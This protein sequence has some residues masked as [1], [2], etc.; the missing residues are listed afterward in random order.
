ML[1]PPKPALLP[2]IINISPLQLSCLFSKTF[3]NKIDSII[4]KINNHTLTANYPSI[5][6]TP[7][8]SVFLSFFR[9]PH[10]SLISKLLNASSSISPSDPVP[11]S[12]FKLYS[13]YLCPTICNII[14]YSL[15]SGTVPSIFKQAIITPILKKPSLDP[16]SLL[17]Y[18]PISQLPLVS[19]ILE[20]VVSRQLISYLTANNLHIPQQ[21]G[22][23]RGHSTETALLN[24]ID[25]ITSTLNTKNCCQ[26]VMLDISSAFDT[27][28]HKILLS[29]LHLLGVRDLALSWFTSYLFDR[30][31]SVKIYNS[32]SSPSPMKYGV[33]QGSVLGPSLFSIY[34]YPLPSIISKYPN[35]YY[36]LYA[37]DIQLY[38]FL[39]T[40][41]SPG[42]N[43]QLSNCANDIKEWLIS[44]NLLLNTS[45]TTLLNLSPSP[46]Y[47]P[48]F[49]IDNIVISPSPTA[50]N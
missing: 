30:S 42:L 45:K 39:P 1:S 41:S 48:P 12:I 13:D 6:V 17:N 5:I 49:L 35:I 19:K 25:V 4:I 38:M 3:S 24:V 14:S 9:P 27:L 31:S 11:L 28:D 8:I 26:L 32:F 47:F 29:R 43:N 16:D 15:N 33:P 36:H 50:S 23:R 2:S 44:N 7:P 20:R 37:D 46:T 34:L 10:I 21:S 22:F 40:N 18:R